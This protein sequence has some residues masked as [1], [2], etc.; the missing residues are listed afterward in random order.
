MSFFANLSIE[1]KIQCGFGLLSFLCLVL[2]GM[3]LFSLSNVN[4]STIEIASSW[5]PSIRLLGDIRNQ[6]ATMQRAVLTDAMCDSTE[7]EAQS[8]EL[9]KQAIEKFK[10]LRGSYEKLVRNSEERQLANEL[11]ED[12]A[13]YAQLSEQSMTLHDSGKKEEDVAFL[14]ATVR[15]AYEKIRAV[16]TKDVELNNTGAE[17]ATKAAEKTYSRSRMIQIAALFIVFVIS[18]VSG[19]LIAHAIATPVVEASQLLERVANKDLSQTMEVKSQDEVGQMVN[20]L[21]TMILSLRQMMQRILNQAESLNEATAQISAAAHQTSTANRGQSEHVQQVAAASQE[22]A[23]VI[24]EISQNTEKAATASRTSVHSAKEGG[25]VVHDAVGSMEHISESN[26]EIVSKMESL[27]N[28]SE[29]IG[30]VVSVIQEIADQTN[31]LALNA[32]IE[33]A[34]AGEHGRGFAVVAGEVRRLAERTRKS[35][36]EIS[37]IINTI[38]Q[39]TMDALHVTAQGKEMVMQGLDKARLAGRALESIINSASSSEEMVTLV[40]TAATEQTSASLEVS[41]SMEKIARMIEDATSASEQTAQACKNLA[42]MA[43]VLESEVSQFKFEQGSSRN[44]RP[45]LV[46]KN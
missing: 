43:S 10:T 37:A 12:V 2:S 15:P 39:G 35:T 5:T 11:D 27:G 16:L 42:S 1:R 33:S 41:Q 28:S 44:F 6:T 26:V 4:D 18:A 19:R 24:A 29:Q 20:S 9:L 23:A 14:N 7:C 3:A 45:A 13:A 30:K 36:E 21:N 22:M 34:R 38:Q 46:S 31:L 25:H 8:R 40:A 17:E 32:A